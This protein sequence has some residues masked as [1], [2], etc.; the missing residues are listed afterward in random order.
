[1]VKLVGESDECPKTV[2]IGRQ[3]MTRVLG[4]V[5]WLTHKFKGHETVKLIGKQWWDSSDISN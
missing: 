5:K 4:Q 1:M 2:Q 3:K